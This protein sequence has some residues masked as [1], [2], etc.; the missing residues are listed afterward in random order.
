M[1]SIVLRCFYV[2]VLLRMGAYLHVRRKC[3]LPI[4]RRERPFSNFLVV[5]Q[6]V[7]PQLTHAPS[8]HSTHRRTRRPTNH[9]LT[10]VTFVVMTVCIFF[11]R[12]RGLNF[13]QNNDHNNNIT[14]TNDKR[15]PII[16]SILQ[17]LLEASSLVSLITTPPQAF[18][19]R[20]KEST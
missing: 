2:Y 3:T 19:I 8:Q 16:E 4:C 1:L 12:A 18:K 17:Y 13:A 20:K 5:S 15:Q 11:P 6:P 9:L 7:V 14:T 10:T